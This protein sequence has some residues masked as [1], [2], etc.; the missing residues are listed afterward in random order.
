MFAIV[1][2]GGMGS[3]LGVA[4]AATVM[5][6]GFELFREFDQYRMLVFGA[7]MVAVVILRPRGL[8]SRRSPSVTLSEPKPPAALPGEPT[9]ETS[10]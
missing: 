6:G 1:V 7:A 9:L 2:L 4:I 5:L 3:Q 8:V 10:Q